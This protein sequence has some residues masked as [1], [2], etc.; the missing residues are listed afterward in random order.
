MNCDQVQGG[1]ITY[2]EER[3][4]E[5]FFDLSSLFQSSPCQDDSLPLLVDSKFTNLSSESNE[6]NFFRSIAFGNNNYDDDDSIY[7]CD[8][9]FRSALADLVVPRENFDVKYLDLESNSFKECIL[10]GT[11]FPS[12]YP[13]CSI[14]FDSSTCDEDTPCS[15]SN[16][17]NE[18]TSQL[19][20][21][22]EVFHDE[23]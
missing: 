2:I 21:G 11:S 5:D 4:I 6:I 10:M 13:L 8:D 19:T 15:S 14:V 23:R 18:L 16:S 7:V 1:H 3:K 20:Q 9:G 17:S 12:H 22:S